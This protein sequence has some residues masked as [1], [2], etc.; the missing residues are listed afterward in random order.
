MVN[1]GEGML[2]RGKMLV[3][4]LVDETSGVYDDTGVGRWDVVV[5]FVTGA[6]AAGGVRPLVLDYRSVRRVIELGVARV[7]RPA[8]L[9]AVVLLVHLWARRSLTSARKSS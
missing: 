3:D 1:D 7:V 4:E 6:G 9:T 2:R 5:L 8:A